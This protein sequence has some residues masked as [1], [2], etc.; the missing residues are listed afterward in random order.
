MIPISF[1]TRFESVLVAQHLGDPASVISESDFFDEIP[2]Y[3]RYHQVEFLEQYGDVNQLLIQLSLEYLDRV[4]SVAR[5]A[6]NKRFIA[7]TVICDDSKF[8][9]PSIF[10]CNG[11][12]ETRLKGLHLSS[13]SSALGKRVEALVNM[14]NSDEDYSIFEDRQTVPDDARIFISYKAPSRGIIKIESFANGLTAP[15]KKT[16]PRKARS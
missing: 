13:P 6:K 15:A 9:V 7:I 2:L 14:A 5:P 10:V 16:Q 3:S 1:R 8:L 4:A 12:F 11:D